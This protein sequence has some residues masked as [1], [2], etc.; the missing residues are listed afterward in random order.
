M[1][2]SLSSLLAQA[3]REWLED[4]APRIGAALAFYT[5]F[6]I[7]PL[8]LICMAVAGMIFGAEAARGGLLRQAIEL[9]GEDGGAAL[10]AMLASAAKPRTGF[11]ATVVAVSMIVLGAIGLFGELQGALNAIW[12]VKPR[13]GRGWLGFLKD[14]LLSFAMVLGTAFLLL[15]SLV[16][17]TA[18]TAAT[19]RLQSSA[20]SELTPLIHWAVSFGIITLLFAMIFRYLPDAVIAWS[21]VWLG[22]LVTSVLFNA[23][24]YAIGVYLAQS[25]VSSAYGA[26]GSLAAL[27]TWLYYESLVFLFGAELTQVYA[28]RFGSGIIP[29]ANAE[30]ADRCDDQ[31]A[32]Q[33]SA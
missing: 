25:A 24:K 10:Q 11:W 14:R 29:N 31:A 33:V 2:T 28:K 8:L 7:A 5:T 9:V 17:S 30:I 32:S 27:L 22:A 3:A 20:F 13:E 19:S 18:M 1:L 4:N 21:D 23:G 26:A 12:N 15:V 6:A 16:A